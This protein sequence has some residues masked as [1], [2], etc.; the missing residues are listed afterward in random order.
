MATL[1]SLN[2]RLDR[3]EQEMVETAPPGRVH[4]LILR[5]GEDENEAIERQK[6]ELG[7]TEHDKYIVLQLVA[8]AKQ[9][10]MAL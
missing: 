1:A 10:L 4:M 2:A 9:W 6:R 7:V 3:L 5:P 8:P